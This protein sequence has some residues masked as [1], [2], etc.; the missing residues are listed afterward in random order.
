MSGVFL[1]RRGDVNG[2][3]STAL[4]PVHRNKVSQHF[5]RILEKITAAANHRLPD[6][7]ISI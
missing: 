7:P 1:W 4:G 6:R 5:C 3:A 2:E